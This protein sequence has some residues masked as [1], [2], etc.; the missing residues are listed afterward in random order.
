MKVSIV[1]PMYNEE[2]N[3]IRTLEI[4]DKISKNFDDYEIIVV[5]DGSSDDTYSLASNFQSN[6]SSNVH[7]L[8]HPVNMG[9]GRALR[10]G[11]EKASGDAIVTIDADLSYESSYIPKLI[12]ELDEST[13]IVVGS[14]YMVGGKTE[15]IPPLRLFISKTA[16]KL[17]GYAMANNLSTVTGVLR[18]YREEV[19]DS[20]ELDSDGTEINPEIISKAKAV[21]FNIK[22]VPVTLKGRELGKSKVRYRR[23]TISHLLFSFYEKPMILFGVIG[24]IICL[25][26]I[27]SAFYLFYQ[28]LIGTLDPT[29]PLML[30]MVLMILSGIQILIFGFVS[31]QISLLK[32]EIYVVQKENKLLRKKL[33]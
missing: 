11:F 9:M 10:T 27:I 26:G 19:L 14:Q 32:R 20:I 15:N 13:D 28:F 30:F 5:D 12:D 6:N 33:K 22:E 4:I 24:L 21:G 16:N 25:I 2:E 18:A 8:K 17:V 31:T 1:I 3:V 29:R 7:I 23:T